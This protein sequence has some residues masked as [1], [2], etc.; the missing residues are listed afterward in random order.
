MISHIDTIVFGSSSS[1]KIP[2][3]SSGFNIRH[4]KFHQPNHQLQSCRAQSS[5]GTVIDSVHG[6]IQADSFHEIP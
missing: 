1:L 2:P 4:Q 5:S 6:N 3:L